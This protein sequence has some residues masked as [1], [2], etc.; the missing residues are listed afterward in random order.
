MW[1]HRSVKY[2]MIGSL[3]LSAAAWWFKDSLPAPE[4]LSPELYDEPKQVRVRKPPIDIR[5]NGIDYRI[6]PRYSYDLHALVVSLHHSDTWWDYVH[7]EW[8]DHINLL[9]LCVVWGETVRSGAYK[10][11][12]FSNNQWECHWGSFSSEAWKDFNQNEVSNNHMVTD[13]PQVA[14][15]LR[16]IHIGDQ[17]RVTG[18]LVDYT[19]FRNDAPAGTRVSSEV[20][21]DTGPGACEVLYIEG[22]EVLGSAGR[23]WRLTLKIALGVL[24]ASV[25]AWMFLPV[26]FND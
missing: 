14:K 10:G 4:K 15:A 9:D 17:I 26:R 11:I 18:Y 22:L 8:N 2:L 13:S 3:A 23:R 25:L 19:I 21:T 6:Q 16:N 20:R 1:L 5:V 7:K 24:L 12:S